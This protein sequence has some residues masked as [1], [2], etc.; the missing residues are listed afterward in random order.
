MGREGTDASDRSSFDAKRMPLL[1][2]MGPGAEAALRQPRVYVAHNNTRY[3]TCFVVKDWRARLAPAPGT[4]AP[5]DLL[6]YAIDEA[7]YVQGILR[8]E[9][10]VRER[11]ADATGVG[12]CM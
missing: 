9:R 5:E 6:Q 2:S 11:V 4:R 12:A 10:A 3:K 1:G 7:S 8:D